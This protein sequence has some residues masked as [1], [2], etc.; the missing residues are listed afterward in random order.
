[1]PQDVLQF[2]K[3][4]GGSAFAVGEQC[5]FTGLGQRPIQ[6][7]ELGIDLVAPRNKNIPACRFPVPPARRLGRGACAV[8][9]GCVDATD[10]VLSLRGS[11]VQF[12]PDAVLLVGVTSYS[13]SQTGVAQY[14]IFTVCTERTDVVTCCPAVKRPVQ[15]GAA[16]AAP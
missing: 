3:H 8:A 13:A 4:G 11:V 5:A 15:G 6:L 7:G 12:A 10:F 14:G 9:L 2:G 1:M 16:A